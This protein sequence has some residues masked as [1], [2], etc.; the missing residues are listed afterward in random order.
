VR[1]PD[2]IL[3]DTVMPRGHAEQSDNGFRVVV[4]QRAI[5]LRGVVC[6]SAPLQRGAEDFH[7]DELRCRRRGFA[8]CGEVYERVESRRHG[9]RHYVVVV[10]TYSIHPLIHSHQAMLLL[11]V[12]VTTTRPQQLLLLLA[13]SSS[14]SLLLL[15]IVLRITEI[16]GGARPL[17]GS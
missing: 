8:G 10:R 6:D 13:S 4:V 11:V 15:L 2:G 5:L 1:R 14:S 3:G 17:F 7:L 12:V 9:G 16:T